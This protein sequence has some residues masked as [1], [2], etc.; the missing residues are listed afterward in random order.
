M[1]KFGWPTVLLGFV[2]AGVPSLDTPAAEGPPGAPTNTLQAVDYAT[3]PAGGALVRVTF[4]EALPEPPRVLVNHYPN[5]RI[6]FDFP[7]TA[8][9]TGREPIGVGTR[10]FRGM[11]VVQSGTRTRLVLI[12][13][14]PFQF[15]TALKDKVL[16]ITLRRPD[17][18]AA[19]GA[20][21]W[22]PLY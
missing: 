14:R 7:G 2:L 21:S 20:T 19:R 22:A 11:Q 1:L 3:L 12:L 8:N 15:E 16:L 13:D 5:Q 10:G 17:P 4:A 18:G 9:A 6:A